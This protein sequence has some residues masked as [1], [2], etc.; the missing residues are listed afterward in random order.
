MKIL[1]TGNLGY[2]GTVLVEQLY[3]D[4]IREIIG[5]DSN[6]FKRCNVNKKKSFVKKQYYLDIR[7]IKKK[8]LEGC[9]AVI[10]LAAISND[11]IGNKFS[12]VTSEIN[13]KHSINLAKLAEKSGVKKFVFASSCS[14]Y[15]SQGF[16][17]KDEKSSLAP[18]TAYAVSK[19]NAEKELKKLKKIKVTCLRFATAC[20]YSNSMRLDLVLN[21]FVTSALFKNK[22]EI[23]SDGKPWR[24]IIDVKDMSRAIIW[25]VLENNKKYLICNVGA[26]DSNYTVLQIAKHVAKYIPSEITINKEAKIDNRSYKVDFSL[27]YK[28]AS[29]KYH[30]KINI[31]QSILE[32]KKN[33]IN[34]KYLQKTEFRE[35]KFIRLNEIN[36]LL[37]S[38]IIDKNFYKIS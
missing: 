36:K 28:L 26:L 24:P 33:I 18:L 10:H 25:S 30:P 4:H 13:Y 27:F 15:G 20:G 31:K 32:I 3:N 1:I 34:L 37:K 14:V 22:I 17:S 35:S 12:K 7:R 2:V 5:Y 11:P 16:R 8:H 21:D 38:K 29:K 23:L 6:L 9:F 19:I